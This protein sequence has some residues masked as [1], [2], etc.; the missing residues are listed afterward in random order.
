[1]LDIFHVAPLI[2]AFGS[3][4]FLA[5][6]ARLR[7]LPRLEDMTKARLWILGCHAQQSLN[8][9]VIHTSALAHQIVILIEDVNSAIYLLGLTLNCQAIIM[10]E[11]GYVKR[12]LEELQ[13]LVQSAKK[14]FNLSGNLYRTSH[15]ICGN[16]PSAASRS[17]N[18]SS[19]DLGPNLSQPSRTPESGQ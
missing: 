9:A 19:S 1:M 13:V 6:V 3:D 14:V 17:S 18:I 16:H 12:R 2:R 11:S 4:G 10:E 5:K 15:K 7:R 8:G